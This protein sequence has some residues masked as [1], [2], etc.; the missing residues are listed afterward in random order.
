MKRALMLCLLLCGLA[1]AGDW[2]AALT[3]DYETFQAKLIYSPD[4]FSGIGVIAITDSYIPDGT[5]DNVAVGPCVQFLVSDIT[6]SALDRIIPGS[7]SMEN[8]PMKTYGTLAF[9]FQTEH[10]RDFVF[11]VG[12]KTILFPEWRIRPCIETVYMKGEGGA[13]I[14]EDFKT[15][16]GFD[17]RF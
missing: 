5:D 2:T 7:W 8:A 15:L 10:E 1:H 11:Q 13:L 16:F 14:D 17:Y 6:N 3:S 4:E 12:T 9:L